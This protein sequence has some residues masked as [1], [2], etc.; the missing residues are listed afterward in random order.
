MKMLQ[1]MKNL[2]IFGL[3]FE[4]L[5]IEFHI[6][7]LAKTGGLLVQLDLV[8]LIAKYSIGLGKVNFHLH[9]LM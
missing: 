8:D 6:F 4:C 9:D 2:L 3:L 5:E 1:E 7:L